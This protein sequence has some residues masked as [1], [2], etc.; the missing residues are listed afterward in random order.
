[1]P[2][3]NMPKTPRTPFIKI[4]WHFKNNAKENGWNTEKLATKSR[5]CTTTMYKR[6][7]NPGNFT[8]NELK[9]ICMVLQIPLEEIL[10]LAK[11]G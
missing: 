1:M 4:A 8:L 10:E 2:R 3:V 5:V 11:E 6:L 9:R 7:R